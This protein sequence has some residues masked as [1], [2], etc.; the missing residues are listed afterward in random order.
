MQAK[1]PNNLSKYSFVIKRKRREEQKKSFLVLKI[2][3]SENCECEAAC[4]AGI[5]FSISTK[6]NGMC[7][8]QGII[9]SWNC[10]KKETKKQKK[11]GFIQIVFGN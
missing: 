4:A 11:S 2:G 10:G 3:K 1:N 8:K 6:I 7:D 5:L 9:S